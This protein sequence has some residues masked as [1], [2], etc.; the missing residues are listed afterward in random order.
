MTY[1]YF[2]KGKMLA[3]TFILC[4][5]TFTF[6]GSYETQI[7]LSEAFRCRRHCLRRKRKRKTSSCRKWRYECIE[8]KAGIPIGKILWHKKRLYCTG[9]VLDLG[10]LH[11]FRVQRR[12]KDWKC[13]VVVEGGG[14]TVL[15]S[16]LHCHLGLDR[17][18]QNWIQ[19]LLW[20]PRKTLDPW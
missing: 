14:H 20:Y 10:F 11:I 15:K 3:T 6:F 19:G 18:V 4:P 5:L 12:R 16:I 9:V 8:S 7:A 1:M 2:G 17:F 13:V